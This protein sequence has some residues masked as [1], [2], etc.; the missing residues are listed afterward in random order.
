MAKCSFNLKLTEIEPFRSLVID[1]DRMIAAY[2]KEENYRQGYMA[3]VARFM[4]FKDEM[5]NESTTNESVGEH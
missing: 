4:K 1:L 2:S 5:M 3:L